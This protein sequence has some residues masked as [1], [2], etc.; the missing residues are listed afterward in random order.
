MGFPSNFVGSF[1]AYGSELWTRWEEELRVAGIKGIQM[2]LLHFLEHQSWFGGA[3]FL[4]I[5]S[6][7]RGL[8]GIGRPHSHNEY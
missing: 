3:W 2:P 5:F 4:A 6:W 1:G 8:D 7:V